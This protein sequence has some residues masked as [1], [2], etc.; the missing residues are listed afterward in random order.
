MVPKTEP[1]IISIKVA[2][3]K[4]FQN[5]ISKSNN[6]WYL[7]LPY[8]CAWVMYTQTTLNILCSTQQSDIC[9]SIWQNNLISFEWIH[10]ACWYLADFVLEKYIHN[11]GIKMNKSFRFITIY[12]RVGKIESK[13]HTLIL[14]GISSNIWN[15][16]IAN[17]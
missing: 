16:T 13:D 12:M 7:I 14:K 17:I 2:T 4:N 8:F 11:H 15:T 6:M 5:C 9:L 1:L 10:H 3:I